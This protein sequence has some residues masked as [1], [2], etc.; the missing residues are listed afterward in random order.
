MINRYIKNNTNADITV[1][2]QVISSGAYYHIQP[3]ELIKF[4]TSSLLIMYISDG[5]CLM[6]K[7]DDGLTDI[8]DVSSSI[9]FLKGNL[10]TSVEANNF[11]FAS[12][13]LP[14]GSKLYKR[15]HGKAGVSV[16]PGTTESVVFTVPYINCKIT[17][18][19]VVGSQEGDQVDFYILDTPT[20]TVSSFP[21]FILNQFGFGVFVTSGIFR[22]GSSYDA[23]LFQGLQLRMDYTN[24]G[25]SAVT[26]N[27]NITLHEVK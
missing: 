2:G 4:S 24:N 21:N 7:S 22:E 11:P 10:P 23:D 27:F 17:G 12:K 15:K 16:A 5:T 13:T 20:G 9:D 3:A 26:P 6:A 19:E 25:Q 18:V 8:I 1:E 14:D